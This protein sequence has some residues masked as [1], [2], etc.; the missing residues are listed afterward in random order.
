MPRPPNA[1]ANAAKTREEAVARLQAMENTIMHT[2]TDLEGSLRIDAPHP[3]VLSIKYVLDLWIS[4]A[5]EW[6]KHHKK[7][8]GSTQV[9]ALKT[10]LAG[11]GRQ[12]RRVA[13]ES[14]TRPEYQQQ[15]RREIR[16]YAAEQAHLEE[17]IAAQE[18]VARA[19][20]AL[21]ALDREVRAPAD[22][23]SDED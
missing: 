8:L 13:A 12:G 19:Q 15:R 1:G 10:R 9:A 7:E 20:A 11:V 4:I 5:L 3:R 23:E 16:R 17:R 2:L 22:T 18:A 21:D 6:A 14:R